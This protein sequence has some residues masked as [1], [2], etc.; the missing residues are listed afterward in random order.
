VKAYTQR[1]DVVKVRALVRAARVS[2]V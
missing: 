1:V 2:R